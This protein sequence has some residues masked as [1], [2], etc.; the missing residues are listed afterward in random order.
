MAAA[1]LSA[2]MRIERI[3]D[4][5]RSVQ[6]KKGYRQEKRMQTIRLDPLIQRTNKNPE[7]S[8]ITESL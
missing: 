8:L 1:V 4:P 2:C 5:R 7:L 3:T 6:I